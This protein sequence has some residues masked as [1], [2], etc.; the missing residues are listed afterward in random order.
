LEPASVFFVLGIAVFSLIGGM[1]FYPV[2]QAFG[3]IACNCDRKPEDKWLVGED[4]P[5]N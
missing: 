1:L 4:K 5:Q 2:L 3:I